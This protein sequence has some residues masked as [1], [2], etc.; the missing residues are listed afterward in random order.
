MARR[1]NRCSTGTTAPVDVRANATRGASAPTQK[2]MAT[3]WTNMAG[4]VSHFGDAVAACP[5]V[6]SE[7]PTPAIART[8]NSRAIILAGLRHA[9]QAIAIDAIAISSDGPRLVPSAPVHG[10]DVASPLTG[11]SSR[12]DTLQAKRD[13]S[14]RETDGK[15][16]P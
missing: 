9:N 8:V 15:R 13:D 10:A 7:S 1:E 3:P 6:A 4:A 2:A 12:V 5:L 11:R 16:A 14:A